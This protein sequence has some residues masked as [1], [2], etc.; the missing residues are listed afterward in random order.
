MGTESYE[1]PGIMWTIPDVASSLATSQW[2]V[3]KA[4]GALA[5]SQGVGGIGILQNKPTAGQNALVMVSGISKAKAGAA[6]TAGDYVTNSAT[7]GALEPA[8]S[9]DVIVGIALTG[10]DT[11]GDLFSLLIVQSGIL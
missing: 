9:A 6:V 3:I 11:A 4:D 10:A 1:I 2:C 7:T 5:D 8:A